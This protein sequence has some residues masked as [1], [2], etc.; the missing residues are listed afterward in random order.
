MIFDLYIPYSIKESTRRKRSKEGFI[1]IAISSYQ[2]KLPV[3]WN[4]YWNS[5]ENM[6]HFQQAFIK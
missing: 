5:R 1:D 2:Q 6:K 3:E 4:K